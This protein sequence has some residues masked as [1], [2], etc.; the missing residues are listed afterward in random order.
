M[1]DLTTIAGVTAEIARLEGLLANGS[2][3]EAREVAIHNRITALYGNL[4]FLQKQQAGQADFKI[5]S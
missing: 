1:A 2:I 5:I 4:V 3:T